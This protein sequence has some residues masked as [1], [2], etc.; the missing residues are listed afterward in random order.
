MPGGA[1]HVL[2]VEDDEDMSDVVRSTLER[3][4]YDVVAVDSGADALAY[5]TRVHERCLV[6]LD[7]HM[8]DMNG[9]EVLSALDAVDAVDHQI[10][11]MTGAPDH[12]VPR[13]MPLLRKP[14]TSDEL[15]GVVRSHM[16][17]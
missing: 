13:G 10:V 4:G 15:L 8:I 16:R 7:L 12:Q 2:V 1:C 17:N 3:A 5:L 14:F 9:W 11:L 6:L